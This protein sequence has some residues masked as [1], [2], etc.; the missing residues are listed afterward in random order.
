[1][2]ERNDK[3]SDGSHFCVVL[4]VGLFVV[5]LMTLGSGTDKFSNRVGV[6][7]F[8]L[9]LLCFIASMI[10]YAKDSSVNREFDKEEEAKEK[11]EEYLR[12]KQKYEGEKK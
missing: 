4:T 11:Y 8:I 1:M 12:L 3:Y 5:G 10:L 6:L 7:C 9:A 2:K